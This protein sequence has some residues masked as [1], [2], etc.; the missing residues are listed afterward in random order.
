MSIKSQL[1][2]QTKHGGLSLA[3]LAHPVLALSRFE[4]LV[5]HRIQTARKV[6]R[7]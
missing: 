2:C 6:V 1:G 4:L 3:Q 5:L 7:Y